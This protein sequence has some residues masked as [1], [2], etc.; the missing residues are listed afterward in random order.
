MNDPT[1]VDR[2]KDGKLL[3][4]ILNLPSAG[5]RVKSELDPT[6]TYISSGTSLINVTRQRFGK[7]E[8]KRMKRERM[9]SIKSKR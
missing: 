9:K 1:K 2:M 3:V 8:T 6:K 4:E 7:A 5:T